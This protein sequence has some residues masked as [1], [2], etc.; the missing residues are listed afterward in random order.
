MEGMSDVHYNHIKYVIINFPLPFTDTQSVH[1]SELS[2]PQLLFHIPSTSPQMH[3][4]STLMMSSSLQ[5][6]ASSLLVPIP[7]VSH[8]TSRFLNSLEGFDMGMYVHYQTY[9]TVHTCIFNILIIVSQVIIHRVL[10]PKIQQQH[11]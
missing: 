5:P 7:S 6:L 9:T 4:T 3:S 11:T 2:C 8:S 10:L 1:T